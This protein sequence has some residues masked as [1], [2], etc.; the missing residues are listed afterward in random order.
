[1]KAELDEI[2][3]TSKPDIF[4]LSP[5]AYA[6]LKEEMGIDVLRELHRYKGVHIQVSETQ[7]QD[8]SFK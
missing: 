5:S 2:L 6:E 1:M 7:E 8:V 3:V 4:I